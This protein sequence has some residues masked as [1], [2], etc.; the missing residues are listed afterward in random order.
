MMAHLNDR[1]RIATFIEK[2]AHC[3]WFF[4]KNQSYHYIKDKVWDTEKGME[5]LTCDEWED[6]YNS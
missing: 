3:I 2:L 6:E 1:N 5:F 4:W